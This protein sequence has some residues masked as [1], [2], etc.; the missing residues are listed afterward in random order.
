[1]PGPFAMTTHA[2][3]ALLLVQVPCTLP[4]LDSLHVADVP[5][6]SEPRNASVELRL[7]IEPNA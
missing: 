7:I 2:G 3:T 4:P 1:V 5:K 6:Q